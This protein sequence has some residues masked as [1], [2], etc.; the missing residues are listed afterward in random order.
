MQAAAT[1][2]GRRSEAEAADGMEMR[3]APSSA[4]AL[5]VADSQTAR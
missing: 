5:A 4:E 1:A 3:R 2:W